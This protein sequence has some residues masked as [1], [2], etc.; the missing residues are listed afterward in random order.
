MISIE[1]A[2][3]LMLVSGLAHAI[4]NAIL[5]SGRD[6]MASRALI[7]GFSA[8]IVL[9]VLPWIELPTHAW[10]WLA[11]SGVIHLVYMIGLIRAFEKA[12]MSVVYPIARG[13]APMLAAVGAVGL[14]GEPINALVVVGIVLVSLGVAMIGLHH[15]V[16]RAAL[17]WA[18]LTGVSIACYTVV[19]AQGVRAA[20][21]AMSYIVWTFFILGGGVGGLFAFWRGPSFI[22]AATS[23][24]R[25]GLSAGALSILTYGLALLALRLGATPRLAALRETSILFGVVIAIVFLKERPRRTQ[26]AGVA[27][28]ALGAI[29]LLV[30]L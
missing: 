30:R 4:V 26:I 22:A 1:L 27:L 17:A 21:S 10:G 24:W 14:F 13:V 7:D 23:Q 20:P 25:A 28:I 8:L 29:V 3:L 19:D 5:K 9:P 11:A 18:L 16:T 12:D 15:T 2:P 6:K